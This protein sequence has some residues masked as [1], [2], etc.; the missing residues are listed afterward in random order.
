MSDQLWS[1]ET[2]F[3]KSDSFSL[4]NL[5]IPCQIIYEN[6]KW[7]HNLYYQLWDEDKLS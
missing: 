1:V 3:Q 5:V 7:E 6:Y 4:I 2:C